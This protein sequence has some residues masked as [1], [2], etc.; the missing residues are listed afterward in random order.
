M[1]VESAPLSRQD[2]DRLLSE[3]DNNTDHYTTSCCSYTSSELEESETEF[4]D[5][6]ASLVELTLSSH[7]NSSNTRR[8]QLTKWKSE[9]ILGVEESTTEIEDDLFADLQK[10]SPEGLNIVG[11]DVVFQASLPS[12]CSFGREDDAQ[13]PRLQLKSILST[14]GYPEVKDRRYQD[15]DDFFQRVTVDRV[16]G[17][18]LE[19][20]K[21]VRENDFAELVCLNARGKRMDSCNRFGESVVHLA[22]R[23]GSAQCLRFLIRQDI[24]VRVC[25]DSGR[26][27]LHDACWTSSPNFEVVLML[28]Q[29]WPDLLLIQDKKGYTPLKYIPRDCWAEW[30]TFLDTHQ[31]SLRPKLFT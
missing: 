30:N 28:I 12:Q 13:D 31:E 14:L 1:V 7:H 9:Y 4:T 19:T 17:Y 18:D 20:V 5:D 3:V 2:M 16:R 6:D 23:R 26:N 25:C 24:N 29:E 11:A 15:V 21:A 27:P 22:A 10:S 8:S